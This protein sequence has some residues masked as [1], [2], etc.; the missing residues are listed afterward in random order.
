MDRL[1]ARLALPPGARVLDAG[2]G[3]G[4][5]TCRL[6]QRGFDC[7]AVDLSEGALHKARER[8]LALGLVARIEF[9]CCGLADLSSEHGPFDAI[10][11]FARVGQLDPYVPRALRALTDF[12]DR[13][14]IARGKPGSLLAIRLQN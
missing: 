14:A 6:A 13:R 10:H 9:L 12:L 4:E 3:T 7:V 1:L 2:C 5:H 11:C 8:A